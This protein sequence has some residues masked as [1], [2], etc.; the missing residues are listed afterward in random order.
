MNTRNKMNKIIFKQ[1]TI[2]FN[3]FNEVIMPEFK[4]FPIERVSI[5]KKAKIVLIMKN[6]LE[7]ADIINVSNIKAP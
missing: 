6:T 5:F 7:Q 4:L 2:I 3:D 1:M